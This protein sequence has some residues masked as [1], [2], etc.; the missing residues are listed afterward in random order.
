MSAALNYREPYRFPAALLALAM[1]LLFLFLLYSS[2]RWQA[3]SSSTE[4]L[5]ISS[6]VPASSTRPDSSPIASA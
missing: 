3:R 2:F 4:A 5:R 6:G 1:H